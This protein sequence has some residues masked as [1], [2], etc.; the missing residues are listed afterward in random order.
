MM[1]CRALELREALSECSSQRPFLGAFVGSRRAVSSGVVKVSAMA[2]WVQVKV[3]GKSVTKVASP[4]G[5]LNY[6]ISK[7][8][9]VR[10]RIIEGTMM[11]GGGV[12]LCCSPRG[13]LGISTGQGCR[14]SP[15][16]PRSS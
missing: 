15:M 9:E 7:Y 14:T 13:T 1:F 2:A 8:C 6:S 4:S 11:L 12:V 5:L 3:F 16:R 10:I